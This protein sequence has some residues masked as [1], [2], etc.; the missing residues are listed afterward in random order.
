[1]TFEILRTN[2]NRVY[3]RVITL[4]L[5]SLLQVSS[6]SCGVPVL[7]KSRGFIPSFRNFE[8]VSILSFN[9]YVSFWRSL[10]NYGL[11]LDPC[12]CKSALCMILQI[13]QS[14]SDPGFKTAEQFYSKYF[15]CI[16]FILTSYQ[17]KI[18]GSLMY[19]TVRGIPLV[20]P[21]MEFLIYSPS[22]LLG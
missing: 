7:S 17:P 9:I 2:I 15:H 3:D 21:Q 13:K 5:W 20:C 4:W 16:H 10:L 8:D 11:L 22:Q 18:G 1:M 6:C 14:P 19:G 12:S